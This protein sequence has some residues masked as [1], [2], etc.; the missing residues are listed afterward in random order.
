MGEVFE[1]QSGEVLDDDF[2]WAVDYCANL[3]ES[4]IDR[5]VNTVVHTGLLGRPRSG[6]S[7]RLLDIASS[8]LRQFSNR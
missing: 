5:S 3:D 6:H 7:H 8:E 1:V 2:W 4:D